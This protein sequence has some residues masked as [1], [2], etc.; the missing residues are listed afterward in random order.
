MFSCLYQE[1]S[2]RAQQSHRG[3]EGSVKQLCRCSPCGVTS[4]CRSFC[5]KNCTHTWVGKDRGGQVR[6]TSSACGDHYKQANK[7]GYRSQACPPISVENCT[8][9][10]VRVIKRIAI[11]SLKI[12]FTSVQR[13]STL[14]LSYFCLVLMA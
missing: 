9:S 14:T 11:H 10:Q 12:Q 1:V 8:V 13:I 2:Y 7:S 3:S 4:C 6:C 5:E